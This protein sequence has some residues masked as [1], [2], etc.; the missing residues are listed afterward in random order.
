M[1][2]LILCLLLGGCTISNIED[3]E[4]VMEKAYFECHSNRLIK[5]AANGFMTAHDDSSGCRY[6]RYTNF[7]IG[8]QPVLKKIEL[9]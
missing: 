6:S 3:Y 5:M 4:V 2:Y 8:L 1:R 9:K 7:Y